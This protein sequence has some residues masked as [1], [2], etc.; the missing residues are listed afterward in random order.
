MTMRRLALLCPLLLT[1]CDEFGRSSH[2]PADADAANPPNQ[3]AGS[4]VPAT[5]GCSND[6]RSVVNENGAPIV[7]C[8]DKEGCAGGLCVPACDAAAVS[9]GSLG[10]DYLVATPTFSVASAPPCFA[11]FVANAWPKPVNLSV[12][13]GS[14]SY[15]LATFAR[16]VVAGKSAA[17]WPPISVGGLAPGTVAALFLSHDPAAKNGQSLTC[18]VGPALSTTGGTAVDGTG[19]GQAWHITSDLPVTA[20]D[21]LPYGGAR[22]FLPSAELV[23]PTTSWGDNFLAVVPMRGDNWAPGQWAQIVAASDNTTVTVLPSVPLPS[24]SEVSP[25][26]A[27]IATKYLL[28]AGE[29][30]QW[31][32][33]N[34]MS[35][36]VIKAD[37]PIAFVGG[38]GFQ[39]YASATSSGGGCD[40]SHQQTAPVSALGWEYAVAPYT[41][42]RMDLQPESIRYRIVGTVAATKLT[43]S[44][45]VVGAPATLGVGQV[46]DFETAAAFVVRSQG[47]DHPFYLAQSMSG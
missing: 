2:S 20:Y 30:I 3:D 46:V 37:H 7:A 29:Y 10:C 40:S 18:P 27:H 16:V 22:T 12:Q 28:H 23:F 8:G 45:P 32:D 44:P 14:M 24:S 39:C 1:A 47:S 33:T 43:F 35:G 21:I 36:T 25:A 31:Q 6:L 5:I 15:N 17:E 4:N 34:E 42:R 13:R 19:R 9:R 38:V 11:V 26:A 41:T